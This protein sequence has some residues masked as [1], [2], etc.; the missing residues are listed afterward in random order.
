VAE[1]K[2][3]ALWRRSWL[4]PV[5]AGVAAAV[6]LLLDSHTGIV[7]LAKLRTAA[8]ALDGQVQ[9]LEARQLALRLSAARL[10]DDPLEIEAVAR[11]SLGMVR[12]GEIVVRFPLTIA[13]V[14]PD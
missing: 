8:A 1:R 11:K 12:P 13:S 5:C 6:I 7:P 3:T 9:T 2:R 4:G 14:G 10:R